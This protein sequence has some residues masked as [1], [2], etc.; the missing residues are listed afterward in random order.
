[1][2]LSLDQVKKI[3]KLSRI[4]MTDEQLKDMCVELENIFNHIDVI[5]KADT[6][7]IE[8]TGHSVNLDSVFR[9]DV[10]EKSASVKEVLKNAPKQE[11]DFFTVRKII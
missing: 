8:P 3:A 10:V 1:M 11:D 5:Q 2:G 6:E 9:N 7:K 4:K